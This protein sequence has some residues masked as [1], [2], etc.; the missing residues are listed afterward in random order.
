[1]LRDKHVL[2]RSDNTATVAYINHQ[3]GLRSRR[4]SQ[5][6]RHLLLWC[7]TGLK[8][9]HATVQLIWSQ[10]GEAQIDLFASR[11]SSH[12]RLFYSLNEAPLSRDALANSPCVNSGSFMSRSLD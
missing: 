7:Q 1:M 3:G 10:F 2:V 11:E 6:A 12:C 8:S 9:L 5:L 4:M